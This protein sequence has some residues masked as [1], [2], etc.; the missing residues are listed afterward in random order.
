MIQLLHKCR[1][2]L[3]AQR[4]EKWVNTDHKKGK[5]AVITKMTFRN[6]RMPSYV[7]E[8]AIFKDCQFENV[9]FS[10]LRHSNTKFIN[11]RLVNCDF[12]YDHLESILFDGCIM[13]FSR[14]SNSKLDAVKFKNC[15]LDCAMFADANIARCE[16]KESSLSYTN[17]TGAKLYQVDIA[18]DCIAYTTAGLSLACPEEGE[19]TA[20]KKVLL[21]TD[22]YGNRKYGIAKLLVPAKAL[23][24][25]ATSR[26]CRV[27][28][29][30]VISI[31]SLDGHTRYKSAQSPHYHS[32][33]YNVG[34]TV[35]PDSFNH[36]RWNECSNGIHCF[37]TSIDAVNY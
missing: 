20:Y 17:F 5:Q 8:E 1:L 18:Q 21:D 34:E 36:D 35:K 29:A 4:H 14:F 30:K 22:K 11:C 25:S 3:M 24:S 26:K 27:S 6:C 32:F 9:D 10:T 7:L 13:P 2:W 23:R 12:M 28:E 31:T 15:V 16:I 37:I 19:F 33:V